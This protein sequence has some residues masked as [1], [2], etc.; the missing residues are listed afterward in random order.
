MESLDTRQTSE[1]CREL[2]QTMTQLVKTH[3]E[4][5]K[6]EAL[7]Q[8]RRELRAGALM[9]SAGLIALY[10]VMFL[11]AAGAAALALVL[12]TWLALL[13]VGVVVLGTAGGMAAMGYARRVKRPLW[14]TRETIEEDKR[15]LKPRT[16]TA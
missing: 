14:R 7:A 1:L 15:W 4:L 11:L 16:T 3:V 6:T 2:V 12:P 5:A 9:A 10:G 8:A 13:I